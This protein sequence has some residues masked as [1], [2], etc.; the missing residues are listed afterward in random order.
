MNLKAIFNVVG[1]LL[2]LLSGILLVPLAVSL[3]YADPA[4]P[5]TERH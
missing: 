5:A 3:F 2:I 1:I 4:L